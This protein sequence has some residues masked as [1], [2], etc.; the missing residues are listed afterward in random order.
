MAPETFLERGATASASALSPGPLDS[1]DADDRRSSADSSVEFPYREYRVYV[2]NILRPLRSESLRAARHEKGLGGRALLQDALSIFIGELRGFVTGC[3]DRK[4]S[5][6]ALRR[7][8]GIESQLGLAAERF[9]IAPLTDGI[10]L[11]DDLHGIWYGFT[12][13]RGWRD[14][15]VPQE[16][17]LSML[18]GA[19]QDLDDDRAESWITQALTSELTSPDV[20]QNISVSV[21]PSLCEL[22]GRLPDFV[23]PSVLRDAL[24][25]QSFVENPTHAPD[26]RNYRRFAGLAAHMVSIGVELESDKVEHL[27]HQTLEMDRPWRER[28]DMLSGIL[29][30][31]SVDDRLRVIRNL[32]RRFEEHA[33]ID[34]FEIVCGI[35]E[36][37]G[38]EIPRDGAIR[39]CALRRWALDPKRGG[40]LPVARLIDFV[41]SDTT[42]GTDVAANLRQKGRIA[43]AALLL[44]RLPESADNDSSGV[45]LDVNNGDAELAR[46]RKLLA[47]EQDGSGSGGVFG[48]VE[49]DSLRLPFRRSS[50]EGAEAVAGCPGYVSFSERAEAAKE[51]AGRLKGAQLLALCFW[52][53]EAPFWH[54]PVTILGMCTE[55]RVELFDLVSL[56]NDSLGG[57]AEAVNRLR[58]LLS[59]PATLK[60]TYSGE[61]AL[62][63]FAYALYLGIASTLKRGDREPLGPLLD[64]RGLVGDVLGCPKDLTAPLAGGAPTSATLPE[65]LICSWPSV[66]TRFLGLRLCLEEASCNWARRPLRE[67]QLH[68]AAAEVW[69]QIPIVR[70]LCAYGIAPCAL[71]SRHTCVQAKVKLHFGRAR[72]PKAHVPGQLAPP[73]RLA[74]QIAGA[75]SPAE[76]AAA[77]TAAAAAEKAAAEQKMKVM[78]ELPVP[79][80]VATLVCAGVAASGALPALP[81]GAVIEVFEERFG[82]LAIVAPLGINGVGTSRRVPTAMLRPANGWEC[83]S[84]VDAL[85]RPRADVV[86]S[87]E[88][89]AA[90]MPAAPSRTE[91]AAARAA[92]T[93]CPPR[94]LAGSAAETVSP[95]RLSKGLVDKLYD[96]ETAKRT[97]QQLYDAQV[98]S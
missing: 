49:E 71:A 53:E 48:P 72:G 81:T 39:R 66:V 97:L 85:P 29:S 63:T 96:V 13:M 65:E 95:A 15:R 68:H 67:S 30:A 60:V 79:T 25:Q 55:H 22:L 62:H 16:C 32:D 91:V 42:I 82:G 2:E 46:L 41:D 59:D 58:A 77:V 34:D 54:S 17:L 14:S 73:G 56:R 27:V 21:W 93:G 86:E 10:L 78:A 43:D 70:A 57:W 1:P 8:R 9:L 51:A 12:I 38:T 6:A 11:P 4:L 35:A 20:H 61:D 24:W 31:A 23:T 90:A 88:E 45:C 37:L 7:A 33:D 36:Y 75:N 74:A 69:T 92:G 52:K 47:C 5:R 80:R 76:R 3:D 83:Q 18:R 44:S 87:A 94:A 19:L 89:A 64:L 84:W 98:R 28:R 50:G 40:A 26:H